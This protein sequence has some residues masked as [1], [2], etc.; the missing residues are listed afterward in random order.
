MLSDQ[1]RDVRKDTEDQIK[2]VIERSNTAQ[3]AALR[4][5]ASHKIK[6]PIGI[7]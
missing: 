3:T 6:G 2:H 5:V 7:S 1:I 4:V